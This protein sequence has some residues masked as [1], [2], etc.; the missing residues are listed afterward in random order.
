MI[1]KTAILINEKNK[2]SSNTDWEKIG[3]VVTQISHLYQLVKETNIDLI[4]VDESHTEL[5]KSVATKLRRYNGLTEIWW[6]SSNNFS[7]E[8]MV[9]FAENEFI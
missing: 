3:I 5:K 4:L 1:Q 8:L 7:D 9:R 6:L 2:K